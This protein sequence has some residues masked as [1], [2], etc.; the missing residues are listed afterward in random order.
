MFDIVGSESEIAGGGEGGGV[1]EGLTAQSSLRAGIHICGPASGLVW[2][3]L[4][5][6]GDHTRRS[7]DL[8]ERPRS[9]PSPSC[10]RARSALEAH[11]ARPI[12]QADVQS[13]V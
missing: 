7:L 13:S 5:C 6:G 3:S 8:P 12:V 1:P 2:A 10:Q 4:P 11:C 9:C